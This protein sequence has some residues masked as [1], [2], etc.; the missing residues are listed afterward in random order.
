[1][2]SCEEVPQPAQ[3]ALASH[4]ILSTTPPRSVDDIRSHFDRILRRGPGS[5]GSSPSPPASPSGS[6][7]S[8]P[9]SEPHPP[10]AARGGARRSLH[11][12]Q[13]GGASESA[14]LEGLRDALAS[15]DRE[16]RRCAEIGRA[17][18]DEQD[19][20]RQQ[21]EE[22]VASQVK[23]L[24]DRAE[25]AEAMVRQLKRRTALMQAQLEEA[26]A[27]EEGARTSHGKQ[28]EALRQSEAARDVLESKLLAAS[29]TC[30]AS[31][32]HAVELERHVAALRKDLDKARA[33]HVQARER[34]VELERELDGQYQHLQRRRGSSAGGGEGGGGGGGGGGDLAEELEERMASPRGIGGMLSPR[35]D[36]MG[37]TGGG[38]RGAGSPVLLLSPRR[39][40][41]E[42]QAE[43][44]RLRIQLQAVDADHRK[45]AGAL[46]AANE[47]LKAEVKELW[48]NLRAA[49]EAERRRTRAEQE[50]EDQAA[51]AARG[52]LAVGPSSLLDE[53]NSVH[54]VHSA[55]SVVR[56]ATTLSEELEELEE[57]EEQNAAAKPP[58]PSSS[59]SPPLP[60]DSRSPPLGASAAAG[61]NKPVA[62]VAA[63]A[64]VAAAGEGG[65]GGGRGGGGGGGTA[66]AT[67]QTTEDH[68]AVPPAID[69]TRLENAAAMA[70]AVLA[71]PESP[72]TEGGERLSRPVSAFAITTK[73]TANAAA[74]DTGGAGT[75]VGPGAAA[76]TAAAN[77]ANAVNAAAKPSPEG[78]DES[79][80]LE[81]EPDSDESSVLE[82]EPDDDDGD[83]DDG[84][85]GGGDGS[86]TNNVSSVPSGTRA[87][88][89]VAP[90][91][92]VASGAAATG[93][94]PAGDAEGAVGSIPRH[95]V[96][97]EMLIRTL[98][99][100]YDGW[101]LHCGAEELR[102]HAR[103]SF[104]FE[105]LLLKEFVYSCIG[106]SSSGQLSSRTP[107][108]D[109]VVAA[110][111]GAGLNDQE[112]WLSFVA[113]SLIG[114]DR[115]TA[116]HWAIPHPMTEP[117]DL[118]L[119]FWMV[120]GVVSYSG[121]D[122]E[123]E[124][125][126]GGDEAA[127]GRKIG[128]TTGS[129]HK[130]KKKNKYED[131]ESKGDDA[132]A[133]DDATDDGGDSG[134]GAARRSKVAPKR[135]P[136]RGARASAAAGHGVPPTLH[137]W[138]AFNSRR[139][140]LQ[141]PDTSYAVTD[142]GRLVYDRITEAVEARWRA[143]RLPAEG[144]GGGG[145]SG[146]G[147]GGVGVLESSRGR[148]GSPFFGETRVD[149]LSDRLSVSFDEHGG[150]FVVLGRERLPAAARHRYLEELQAACQRVPKLVTLLS[151]PSRAAALPKV[152]LPP[153]RTDTPWE[154]RLHGDPS[155]VLAFAE[156]G[157]TWADTDNTGTP[158]ATPRAWT[159]PQRG[160]S[161]ISGGTRQRYFE[162]KA[163]YS[164]LN[165]PAAS[166]G[167]I[168]RARF[169]ACL[170][171][172]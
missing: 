11:K 141:M 70:A 148:G 146:G 92:S 125:Q 157:V 108:V 164:K 163:A 91:R 63:A 156:L 2:A 43:A 64:A 119:T 42:A 58:S 81:D 131:E 134:G 166:P 33:L 34:S 127:E 6:S 40:L 137:V 150:V 142:V 79:E 47:A 28:Q 120:G 128:S 7:P 27:D 39:D 90:L 144:G 51:V 10:G 111:E 147:G 75:R 107:K 57:L 153:A 53:L 1:M 104:Y 169:L 60:W 152:P 145:G 101:K 136:V 37:G 159:T 35:Q 62:G 73:K 100:H 160:R 96:L 123:E 135:T 19:H 21:S 87:A 88:G 114:L 89:G 158:R 26:E 102:L 48:E 167:A 110:L 83:G 126:Q 31:S 86:T 139:R 103:V 12:G 66:P 54:S 71:E 74:G 5:S 129:K 9:P 149:D 116:T 76:K 122:D 15:R 162:S 121:G 98:L 36:G 84:V 109:T 29:R 14:T 143:G 165:D 32:E 69:S 38:S 155:T 171:P 154:P 8:L 138:A 55:R 49:Q 25:A 59:H 93:T 77:D 72:S 112:Q 50:D 45:E 65:G 17:L 117:L 61:S 30:Q 3:L 82:D 24:R 52:P 170:S 133:D 132:D 140:G 18:L 16:L 94:L 172:R 23:G 67:N 20:F 113:G 99:L 105:V 56:S 80:E 168:E 115:A 130:K 44:E 151:P 4:A 78:Q 97:S 118:P 161:G 41:A 46:L 85:D 106:L 68:R 95:A 22:R 124:E 13:G